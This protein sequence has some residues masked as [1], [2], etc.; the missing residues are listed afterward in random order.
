MQ[1]VICSTRKLGLVGTV[2][3]IVGYDQPLTVEVFSD[4]IIFL[5]WEMQ[6]PIVYE[7]YS[8]DVG[9][10]LSY[11]EADDSYIITEEML[12]DMAKVITVIEANLVELEEWVE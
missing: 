1:N 2:K 9:F 11:L 5:L 3:Q 8:G 6:I 4:E 12:R 7:I 10:K